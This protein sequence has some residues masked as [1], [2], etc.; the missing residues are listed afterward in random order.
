MNV[1]VLPDGTGLGGQYSTRAEYPDSLA[2][3]VGVGSAAKFIAASAVAFI[4]GLSA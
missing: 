4:F 1:I 2:T 3:S